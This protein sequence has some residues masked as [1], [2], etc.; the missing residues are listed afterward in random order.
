MLAI[1]AEGLLIPLFLLGLIGVSF[2][3][4]IVIFVLLAI[5]LINS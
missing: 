1:F 4:A 5:K 2:F 3:F